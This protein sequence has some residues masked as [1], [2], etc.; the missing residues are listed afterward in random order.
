MDL[1]MLVIVVILISS[2]S[3]ENGDNDSGKECVIRL[4]EPRDTAVLPCRHMVRDPY[5]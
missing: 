3:D 5:C 2:T 4:S 1:G